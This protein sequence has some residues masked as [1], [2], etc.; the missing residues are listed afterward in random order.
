MKKAIVVLAAVMAVACG[1]EWRE[2]TVL[3][4]T[5]DLNSP[6]RVNLR[7]HNQTTGPR[8][9]ALLYEVTPIQGDIPQDVASQYKGAVARGDVLDGGSFTDIPEGGAPEF[10]ANAYVTVSAS[11]WDPKNPD[12][13]VDTRVSIRATPTLTA[14][15]F[16]YSEPDNT[17][18][19]THTCSRMASS[20]TI[21]A[22]VSGMCPVNQDCTYEPPTDPAPQYAGFCEATDSACLYSYPG[23]AV[24]VRIINRWPTDSHTVEFR[25]ANQ[26][27]TFDD[28]QIYR[29]TLGQNTVG[30]STRI[31]PLQAGQFVEFR[32]MRGN[33]YISPWY[34]TTVSAYDAPMWRFDLTNEWNTSE[35]SGPCVLANWETPY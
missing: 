31:L 13:R 1:E 8:S 34:G 21:G 22:V 26:Y 15:D 19:I 4:S 20:E 14:C 25:Y 35:C 16:Y 29:M 30:T 5:V 32:V 27:G 12:L 9:L 17:P 28:Y 18:T 23:L 3:D 6:I 24:R 7:I 33:G 11:G 2:A 10:P